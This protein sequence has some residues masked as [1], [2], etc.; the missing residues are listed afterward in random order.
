MERIVKIYVCML[1]RFSCVWDRV[2][3]WTVAHQAPLFMGFSRQESWSES[4]C[5][6]PGNLP[7]L[8]I[9]GSSLWQAGSLPLAPPGKAVKIYTCWRLIYFSEKQRMR[10]LHLIMS[11][12]I[13][14]FHHIHFLFLQSY[15]LTKNTFVFWLYFLNYP[16]LL[17]EI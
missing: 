1:S 4:P 17:L 2:T 14:P 9:E 15:L 3:P 16:I 5:P 12:L 11:S 10:I 8:G 7:D 13:K 6:P